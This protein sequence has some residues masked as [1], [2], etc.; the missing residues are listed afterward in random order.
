MEGN[1]VDGGTSFKFV[2][3]FL[4]VSDIPDVYF[5][6]LTTSHDQFTIGG[7]GDSIDVG[8]VCFEG[9][10]EGVVEVPHFEPSVPTNGNEVWADTLVDG[11]ESYHADPV[12][13]IVLL[14]CEFT[15]S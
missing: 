6:V 8:F 14:G 4:K 11:G 13:V 9:V 12:G 7:N 15:F 10:S 5:F 2:L 3:G 1:L